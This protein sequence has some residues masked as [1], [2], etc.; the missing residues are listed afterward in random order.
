MR[1]TCDK[2]KAVYAVDDKLIPAKGARAVPQ[3]QDAA[4]GPSR[5]FGRGERAR[6]DHWA[7]TRAGSHACRRP[8]TFLTSRVA[9]ARD[10]CCALAG[11]RTALSRAA[12]AFGSVCHRL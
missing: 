5:R 6:S 1:V 4:G 3:V 11:R 12:Q 10:A 9:P 8:V 2:C 7:Q